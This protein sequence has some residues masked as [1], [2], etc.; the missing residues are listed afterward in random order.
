MTAQPDRTRTVML[1]GVYAVM[2]LYPTFMFIQR[3][4]RSQYLAVLLLMAIYGFFTGRIRPSQYALDRNDYMVLLSFALITIVAWAS[5]A[6]FGFQEYA[7]HRVERYTWFL[8]AIPI[9]YLFLYTKPRMEIIW[10][11]IVIGCFV[12]FGRA[13][14]E[15]YSLV[16]EIVW[17]S[18]KGRANG[19]MHPI[20]F[21]DLSLL[22]G[23]IA[24]NGVLNIPNLSRLLRFAGAMGF[25]A[26]LGASI[27]SGSR[28]GWI[29]LPI[30][31]AVIMWFKWRQPGEKKGSVILLSVALF[32]LLAAI[33]FNHSIQQRMNLA[34]EEVKIYVEKGE[35]RSSIGERFEMFRTAVS[36]FME[37]PLFGVG[38]GGYHPYTIEYSKKYNKLN[39]IKLP[40]GVTHWKNPHN[41]FL[42]HASTRGVVGLSALIF[43]MVSIVVSGFSSN[44]NKMPFPAVNLVLLGLGFS[45]FGLSIALFEHKDFL[46][47]FLVYVMV[48]LAFFRGLSKNP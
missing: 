36:A 9:Y 37:S 29:A 20:R 42:L 30:L 6:H 26:G 48:F 34:V 47:F 21:G 13:V 35:N 41:E 22:M 27:L 32:T 25:V 43:M 23:C 19:S 45:I 12:A 46:L 15:E 14:L 2:L 31:L 38:V 8:L 28:G 4:V 5:Y 16:D 11:G 17:A 39:T 7:K 24:L 44:N 18:M 10:A 33:L 3:E 40:W 1:F